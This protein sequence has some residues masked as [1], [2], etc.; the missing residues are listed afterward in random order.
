M[1]RKIP[2][3]RTAPQRWGKTASELLAIESTGSWQKTHASLSFYL[4]DLAKTEDKTKSLYWRLLAAG[5]E[6][7]QLRAKFD[8]QGKEFPA[9]EESGVKASPESLELVSKI[10]RVA[11]AHV[12]EALERKAMR[13]EISR[14]ELRTLWLAYR[15]VLGGKTARGRIV[16]PHYDSRNQTMRRALIEANSL[17][18]LARNGPEWL[19]SRSPYVYRIV[20]ISSDDRL[21]YLYPSVPDA[22]VVFAKREKDDIELHGVEAGDL[23]EDNAVL[24]HYDPVASSVD[25]LWFATPRELGERDLARIPQEIGILRASA[26]AIQVVRHAQA[27]ESKEENKQRLLRAILREMAH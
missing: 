10:R 17:A 13:G 9:L 24:D 12:M 14:R 18:L 1:D 15:P 11:P 19:G 5:R 25:F 3:R 20:H 16:A 2:S 6:Y 23:I 8:P 22:V 26:D 27:A 7:N 21:R 4:S